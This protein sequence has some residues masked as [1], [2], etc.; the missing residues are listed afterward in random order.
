MSP[1]D[2]NSIVMIGGKDIFHLLINKRMVFFYILLMIC[3]KIQEIVLSA[4]VLFTKWKHQ[5]ER[6]YLRCLL[7]NF[8]FWQSYLQEFV[9]ICDS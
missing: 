6:F 1:T 2:L 3:L 4:E 5:E 7:K 8:H 9:T